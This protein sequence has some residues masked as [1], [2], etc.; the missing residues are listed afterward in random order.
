VATHADYFAT[1]A[2][3]SPLLHTWTLAIEEQFYL[4]WPL[5]LVAVLGGL[6]LRRGDGPPARRRLATLGV[7]ALA[8][9]AASATTM[10]LLTPV[11]ATSVDRAYYGSDTRAQGLLIGAALAV[12]CRLRGPARTPRSRRLLGAAGVAGAAGV[13]VIWRTVTEGSALTFH[14]GFALLAIG[15]AAVI[16][17]VTQAP[18]GLLPRA[19]SLRPLPYLGRI[20][21]GMY[22]WYWPVLLVMTGGRT[23]LH[24]LALLG[25]RVAVI[26]AVAAA[27]FHLLETPVRRGALAGWRS[28]A[29]APAAALAVSVVPLLVSLTAAAG[30]AVA[31]GADVSAYAAAVS[32]GAGRPVRILVVGDSVAGSLGVGLSAV[33]PRYGAEVVNRG[34]PGCSLAEAQQVRVL[35]YTDPPGAP[36]RAEHPA[37]LLTAYR[38]MVLRFYPD[39]VVYLARGDTLD[40]E[41]GGAWE[42]AGQ[43]DFDRWASSRFGRAVAVLG[44]GGAHVVLM[45]SPLYDS[46]EQGNGQPWPENDPARVATVNRLLAGAARA[47]TTPVTLVD[48]GSLLSPAGRFAA[49]VNGVP[50]RCSDGVH[51]TVAG[52]EWVG[53]RLLPGLVALGRAHAASPVGTVRPAL[54]A[55]PAAPWWYPKLSCGA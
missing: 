34:M 16:A 33:A 29:A 37:Q 9:A 19:L 3:P 11:G 15:T 10:A 14:G 18:G 21:Y 31:P 26:V 41:R 23:H 53:S 50:V 38:A 12:A 8:G 52:G 55:E 25:A 45:T 7:L 22:L 27:S 51:V 20:S 6:G 36:C 44:S 42:H 54:G 2:N 28:W 30:P 40:T 1:A 35:W 39:V 17:A 32:R 47:S 49:T 4:V 24:G 46:G 13:V 5:V 48:L 43:A